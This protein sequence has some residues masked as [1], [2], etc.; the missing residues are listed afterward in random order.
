MVDGGE[1]VAIAINPSIFTKAAGAGWGYGQQLRVLALPRDRHR[2]NSGG[3][4]QEAG[5]KVSA[6]AA[7]ADQDHM[8]QL[9]ALLE[10]VDVARQ[11][12]RIGGIAFRRTN[13]PR[14]TPTDHIASEQA[15]AFRASRAK[16][17]RRTFSLRRN[18]R[19][20]P[21]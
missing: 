2:R 10:L 17:G 12:H 8:I 19:P 7:I 14:A 16:D 1:I 4:A 3:P 13:S 21:R 6:H 5:E 15:S 9:E 11:R 18:L 20:L